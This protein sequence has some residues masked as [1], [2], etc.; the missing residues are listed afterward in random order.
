MYVGK[1]VSQSVQL[2]QFHGAEGEDDN[3]VKLKK[4]EWLWIL[5]HTLI[6]P[7]LHSRSQIVYT[8]STEWG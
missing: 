4:M 3:P 7:F 6:N 1:C 8:I 5:V 2:R